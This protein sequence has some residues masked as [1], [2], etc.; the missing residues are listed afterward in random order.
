[1]TDY[2]SKLSEKQVA[3]W[4]GRLAIQISK[5]KVNNQ[6]PLAS[7][8]LREWLK[9]RNPKFVYTFH[10]PKHLKESKYVINVLKY[11]RDVFLTQK[12][13]KFTGKREAWAG[14]LPRLQGIR[15]YKKWNLSKPLSL[16]YESLVEIG[17]GYVD[18]IR[19]Q[20][21]GTA[22]ERDLL[23]SLRGFQL[24]STVI[25]NGV[26]SNSKVKINFQSWSCEVSDTYDFNYNEYFTVPNPDFGK[27][28]MKGAVQPNEKSIR[29][30]QKNAKRLE[31]AN[32]SCPYKIKSYKWQVTNLAI[33]GPAEIDINRKIN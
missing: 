13:A 15:G 14:I 7:I 24:K 18:L 23:T 32:L 17:N 27:N 29:V 25:I 20:T 33:T 10:P 8:F 12:K 26:Q 28:N 19:I 1:M 5:T 16:H 31:D 4:Y 6:E 11:H 3:D 30:Y 21:S 22:E 2:L 9:N